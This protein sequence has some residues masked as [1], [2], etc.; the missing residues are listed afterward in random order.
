MW[1]GDFAQ[2]WS[3][4]G[5]LLAY[6][7]L[8]SALGIT[9]HTNLTLTTIIRLL[10]ARGSVILIHHRFLEVLYCSPPFIYSRISQQTLRH[11]V[12][13]TPNETLFIPS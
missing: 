1:I 2:S 12:G 11:L 7:S 6:A 9:M 3:G 10:V 8:L 13:P 4:I 5:E